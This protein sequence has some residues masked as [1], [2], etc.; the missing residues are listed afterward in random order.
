[1]PTDLATAIIH[2]AAYRSMRSEMKAVWQAV[3]APC[4]ICGIATIDWDAPKNEP[5]AFELDHRISRKRCVAMNR[6]DLLLD[7][8]NAQP[9]HHK[10]NRSK[11]AGD[12]TPPLGE[13][14]EEY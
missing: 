2:S 8:G 13:T 10:C 7:P 14:S 5:D 9:S 1:M 4:G 11:G 3:N 6:P 12:G